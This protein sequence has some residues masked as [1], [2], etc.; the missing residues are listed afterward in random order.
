[1]GVLGRAKFSDFEALPSTVLGR[2]L[3]EDGR[4]KNYTWEYLG[5]LLAVSKSTLSQ[6]L[7]LGEKSSPKYDTWEY[8]GE[9]R[10]FENGV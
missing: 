10:V 8:L 7:Y 1:M 2:Y 6:V 3:G 9:T 4:E 5:E